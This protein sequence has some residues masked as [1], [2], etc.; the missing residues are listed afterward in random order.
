MPKGSTA[1]GFL[2][3]KGGGRRQYLLAPR[4][5]VVLTPDDDK[6]NVNSPTAMFD[7]WLVLHIPDGNPPTTV[8][9][10]GGPFNREDA[11]RMIAAA[12][13]TLGEKYAPQAQSGA[14]PASAFE[15]RPKN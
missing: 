2:M 1:K 15:P 10:D 8:R 9:F 4:L 6:A 11:A 13:T 12:F 3:N 7:A 14:A 5:E